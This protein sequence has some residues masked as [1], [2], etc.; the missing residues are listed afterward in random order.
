VNEII[1]NIKDK[2][3]SFGTERN[4]IVNSLFKRIIETQIPNLVKFIF[5]SAAE[6]KG[7]FNNIFLEEAISEG[8]LRKKKLSKYQIEEM[9]Q[10]D[11]IDDF[12]EINYELNFS[13]EQYNIIKREQDYIT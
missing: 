12:D 11:Q 3:G 7:I 1:V 4:Q 10:T 6:N 5:W 8:Q 9:R 13:I 2:S